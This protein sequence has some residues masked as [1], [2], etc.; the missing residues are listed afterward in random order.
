MGNNAELVFA[1]FQLKLGSKFPRRSVDKVSSQL[2]DA[3]VCVVPTKLGIAQEWLAA[4]DTFTDGAA[5]VWEP[6]NCDRCID[7][8]TVRTARVVLGIRGLV[9]VVISQ[10][11]DA[12][13][14]RAIEVAGQRFPAF[15]H[16]R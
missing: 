13:Q 1:N 9:N 4:A 14:E 7:R 5:V 10:R 8:P 3:L 16:Q 2:P 11:A 15:A 12:S 6:A